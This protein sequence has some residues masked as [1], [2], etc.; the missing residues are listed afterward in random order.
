MACRRSG[1]RAPLSPPL[2]RHYY[3]SSTTP[4]HSADF[5][6]DSYG[7][8]RT[9]PITSSFKLGATPQSFHCHGQL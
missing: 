1:V 4:L 9:H 8:G 5:P 6:S 7:E 2:L 3:V